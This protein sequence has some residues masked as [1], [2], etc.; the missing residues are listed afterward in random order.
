MELMVRD[1]DY[2]S[3][4]RG[5]FRRAEGS[6][7]LL[8]RV[9]WKLSIRRGCFP[10]LPGLGSQLYRLAG[11]Q[12]ARRGALAPSICDRGVGRGGVSACGRCDFK[13]HGHLTGQIDLAG[14]DAAFG[15][16]RTGSVKG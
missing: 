6:A 2:V 15:Y 7:E 3:D 8:Q 16:G 14:R 10:P 13:R 9:L 5:S 11:A 12:P 1:G 4:G